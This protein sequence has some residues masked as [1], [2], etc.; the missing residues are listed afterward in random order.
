MCGDGGIAGQ[1]AECIPYSF[2]FMCWIQLDSSGSKE[3]FG[4]HCPAAC[5]LTALGLGQG[6][7][8]SSLDAWQGQG[9]QGQRGCISWL[10]AGAPGF[11]NKCYL[12]KCL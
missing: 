2:G 1:E 12:E 5:D 3:R 6:W 11:Q 4:L 10:E 8:L 7:T 9:S